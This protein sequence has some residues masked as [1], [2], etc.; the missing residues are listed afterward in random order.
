MAVNKITFHVSG[1]PYGASEHEFT[2]NPNDLD[3]AKIEIGEVGVIEVNLSISRTKDD[4]LVRGTVRSQVKQTCV[5]CLESMQTDLLAEVELIV[6]PCTMD[7]EVGERKKGDKPDSAA[8][9]E[10]ES[11]PEGMLYHNGETFCLDEEIRQSLLVE[12]PGAPVCQS[13]CEGLCLQCGA[14]L[15]TSSC[16]C[17]GDLPVDPR[18][19]ALKQL[20]KG[21]ESD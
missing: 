19:A 15:S 18:W 4:F 3:L 9:E 21:D 8:A 6:R 14:N 11:A 12:I 5:R 1:V 20:K 13:S 10:F 17:A 7:S 16:D 2:L